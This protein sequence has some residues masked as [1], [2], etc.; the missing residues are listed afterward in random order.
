MAATLSLGH[1]PERRRLT[2]RECKAEFEQTVH[3]VN[4]DSLCYI[5]EPTTLTN[6][7]YDETLSSGNLVT[8]LVYTI[9]NRILTNFSSNKEGFT[10]TWA[11]RVV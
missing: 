4:R 10:K 11:Y 5:I 7:A 6:T 9:S 8:A 2:G 3:S 1:F